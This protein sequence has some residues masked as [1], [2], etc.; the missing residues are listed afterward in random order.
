MA[1]IHGCCSVKLQ[2]IC[3]RLGTIQS[4][5][6]PGPLKIKEKSYSTDAPPSG[7]PT[8]TVKL[9]QARLLLHCGCSIHPCWSSATPCRE[10]L[11]CC[12]CNIYACRPSVFTATNTA[13]ARWMHAGPL[14]FNHACRSFATQSSTSA[15]D[16]LL[17]LP[18]MLAWCLTISRA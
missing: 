2:K 9:Y 1:A 5:M 12:S 8:N 18:Y 15:S 4:D 11:S 17:Y 14:P 10:L 6:P 13:A 3:C 7:M 16:L